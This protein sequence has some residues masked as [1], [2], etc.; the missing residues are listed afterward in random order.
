MESALRGA[1]KEQHMPAFDAAVRPIGVAVV[2]AVL[3]G[4]WLMTN[5]RLAPLILLAALLG[6][7]VTSIRRSLAQGNRSTR[8]NVVIASILIAGACTWGLVIA[9]P[10]F[11]AL[12]VSIV[13]ATRGQT[14]DP[15]VRPRKIKQKRSLVHH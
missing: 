5:A 4:V 2:G 1:S 13:F 10:L 9:G 14:M 7:A 3:V 6:L 15:L 11:L 8:E 12:P